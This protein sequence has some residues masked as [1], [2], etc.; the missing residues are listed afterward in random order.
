MITR[1][2][3][4]TGNQIPRDSLYKEAFPCRKKNSL[5]RVITRTHFSSLI[6]RI[7]VR[8]PHCLAT[9]WII[10]SMFL[11]VFCFYLPFSL[12]PLLRCSF[13][14]LS[15]LSVDLFRSTG[16]Q[17][18]FPLNIWTVFLFLIIQKSTRS[19]TALCFITLD[20]IL[21]F[22]LVTLLALIM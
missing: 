2:W 11:G 15:Y 10:W 21:G 1:R 16:F 13:K 22:H 12:I 5:T 7:F 8:N 14:R 20:Y 6:F 18:G 9:L 3:C 17:L 4:L 19:L